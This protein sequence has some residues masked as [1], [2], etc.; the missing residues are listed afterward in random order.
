MKLATDCNW[1]L[2]SY[3]RGNV[4]TAPQSVIKAYKSPRDP[5]CV[6]NLDTGCGA[7]Y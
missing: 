4:Y 3:P 5:T 1:Q 6:G 7:L 2:R